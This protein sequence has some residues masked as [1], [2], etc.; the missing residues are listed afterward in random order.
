MIVD[1]GNL[2]PCQ[3]KKKSHRQ[4]TRKHTMIPNIGNEEFI[5]GLLA[6]W[7]IPGFFY[8][9]FNIIPGISIARIEL[10]ELGS[11]FPVRKKWIIDRIDF[12]E[13]CNRQIDYDL[14]FV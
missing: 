11:K 13:K 12:S 4:T 6:N 10:L 5:V 1:S 2:P 9:Y 3:F 8:Y 14:T 7:P